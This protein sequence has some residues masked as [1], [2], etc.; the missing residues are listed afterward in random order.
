[1]S[2]SQGATA[3]MSDTIIRYLADTIIKQ[4]RAKLRDTIIMHKDSKLRDTI[5]MHAAA[6]VDSCKKIPR[7][8][9]C[10]ESLLSL[11]IDTIIK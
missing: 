10:P 1:M 11:R 6:T 7:P 8:P 4:K 9:D 3:K 2:E 5:I